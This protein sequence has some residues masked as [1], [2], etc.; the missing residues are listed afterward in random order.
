MFS[1]L[2]YHEVGLMLNRCVLQVL[3]QRWVALSKQANGIGLNGP[4]LT[5]PGLAGPGYSGPGALM[6]PTSVTSIGNSQV[7]IELCTALHLC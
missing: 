1:L 6:S 7:S 4:G 2:T 3:V 5:G